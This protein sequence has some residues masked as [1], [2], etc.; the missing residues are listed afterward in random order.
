MTGQ[1][2][3]TPD[4]AMNYRKQLDTAAEELTEYDERPPELATPEEA[5][6]PAGAP[7][8]TAPAEPIPA[9]PS[10]FTRLTRRL[11]GS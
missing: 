1:S 6:V 7:E 9:S 8:G 5:G 3:F 11:R 4:E 2:P 10:W